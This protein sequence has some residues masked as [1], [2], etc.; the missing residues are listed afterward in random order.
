MTSLSGAL[1]DETVEQL[2]YERNIAAV[3]EGRFE[4][5]ETTGGFEAPPAICTQCRVTTA[6]PSGEWCW[7]CMDEHTAEIERA[8]EEWRNQGEV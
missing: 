3:L 1:P 5:V 6:D 4:D 2:R 8:N 7:Q